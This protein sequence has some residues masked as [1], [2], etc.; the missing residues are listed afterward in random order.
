MPCPNCNADDEVFVDEYRFN[1]KYDK[2]YLGTPKIVQCKSC[3]FCYCNPMPDNEKLHDY[4]ETIYRTKGRP[5]WFDQKSPPQPQ[6]RHKSYI[7]ALTNYIKPN[8]IN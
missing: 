2:E 6:M 8:D 5:H 1:I 7:S 4:Y 3:K